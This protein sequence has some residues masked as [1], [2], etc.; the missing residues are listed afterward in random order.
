MNEHLTRKVK[1]ACGLWLLLI[2]AETVYAFSLPD[3][4]SYY[5]TGQFASSEGMVCF[6]CAGAVLMSLIAFWN[7]P[8]LREVCRFLPKWYGIAM[9]GYIFA[10]ILLITW[11]S[12]GAY[13]SKL[14]KWLCE[15]GEPDI[16]MP[17]WEHYSTVISIAFVMTLIVVFSGLFLL[18]YGRKRLRTAQS[19]AQVDD[20]MTVN[21]CHPLSLLSSGFVFTLYLIWLFIQAKDC[22]EIAT[23]HI[24]EP[25]EYAADLIHIIHVQILPSTCI[26]FTCLC[27]FILMN[28]IEIR[29]Y[30]AKKGKTLFS[31]ARIYGCLHV[32]V[33]LWLI[34]GNYAT[35]WV[36]GYAF[37]LV[38]AWCFGSL[39]LCGI[40]LVLTCLGI[41]NGT[42]QACSSPISTTP[43]CES[44]HTPPPPD[45]KK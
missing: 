27:L 43:S 1:W 4:M 39:C 44:G 37:F 24:I 17:W 19:A 8:V 21:S 28:L 40:I 3:E 10:H 34:G 14:I 16:T 41:R 23:T 12:Q 15:L 6:V 31:A 18:Y 42:Q 36:G 20:N 33:L 22:T 13:T 45:S 38:S 9:R 26:V 29:E 35:E 11:M 30:C 2:I 5:G 32:V 7:A 25:Y